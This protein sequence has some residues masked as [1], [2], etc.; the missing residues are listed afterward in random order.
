MKKIALA[1][2]ASLVAASAYASPV[3]IQDKTLLTDFNSS[4]TADSR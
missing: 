1:V 3:D 4:R 2:M